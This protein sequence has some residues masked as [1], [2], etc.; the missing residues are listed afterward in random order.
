MSSK[1]TFL[2]EKGVYRL[3]KALKSALKVFLASLKVV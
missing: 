2:R 1:K 3:A